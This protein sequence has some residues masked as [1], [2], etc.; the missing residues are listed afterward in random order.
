MLGQQVGLKREDAQHVVGSAANLVHPVG[1]PSPDGRADK[2]HGG[3]ALCLERRLQAQVEVGRI[4]ANKD[5]GALAQQTFAQL[6]ANAQQPGHA[7]E[8]FDAIAV[9][10]QTFAG[11]M[12]LE[13]AQGHLWAANAT[14]LKV[15][16]ARTQSVQHQAGEQVAGGLAGHHGYLR[17]CHGQRAMPLAEVARKL[18]MSA[19][20]AAASGIDV[21]S[22]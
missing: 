11:P 13:P 17:G 6:F 12:G 16:P 21:A 4:H 2:V 19:T 8:Y 5:A 22:P 9:Y 20:S 7:L 15:R 1:A 18:S 14:G 10:G 3:D